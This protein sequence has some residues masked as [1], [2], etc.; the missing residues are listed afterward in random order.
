M[1]GNRKL[2]GCLV[3]PSKVAGPAAFGSLI[4]ERLQQD[5][6][7]AAIRPPTVPAGSARLR[8]SITLAHHVDDLERAARAIIREVLS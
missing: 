2:L 1:P 6:I 7:A 5:I 8:I 4:T 3:V